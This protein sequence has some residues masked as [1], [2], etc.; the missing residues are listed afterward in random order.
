MASPA[1]KQPL[2]F[3]VPPRTLAHLRRRAREAGQPQTALAERYIEEG[4]RMDEHPLIY[5]RDGA[6]GR[7]PT[8]L[9]T[10]L[11][12][13]DVI[14]TVWQNDRSVEQAAAYLELPVDRVEACLRYYADYGAEIDDW[15]DRARAV[16]ER[17]EERWRRRGEALA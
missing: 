9:G 7:R 8:L 10:R 12:V 2:G 11:D 14:E 5:F 6:N 17:E 3:R 15:I 13:A 4:L 1:P 16:A